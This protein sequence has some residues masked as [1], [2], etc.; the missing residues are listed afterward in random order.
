M[1]L[2]YIEGQVQ[3]KTSLCGLFAVSLSSLRHLVKSFVNQSTVFRLSASSSPSSAF[4]NLENKLLVSF[5]LDKRS[6]TELFP[7]FLFSVSVQFWVWNITSDIYGC[8]HLPKATPSCKV[9]TH[10][11]C[12]TSLRQQDSGYFHLECSLHICGCVRVSRSALGP[13]N[14]E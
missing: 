9:L 1:A 5:L 6:T 11:L 7:C 3:G 4:T 14:K 12:G 10:L 8:S 2:R 13:E